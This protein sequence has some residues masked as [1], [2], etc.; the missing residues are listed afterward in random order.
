MPTMS[1]R[2]DRWAHRIE[3]LSPMALLA[4]PQNA[5]THSRAQRRK[6]ERSIRRFGFI[7]P[8]IIDESRN[9]IAGHGRVQAALE[10]GLDRVPV[11][12]IEG[13]SEAEK[14]AYALADNKIA[15]EAGWDR[16]LLASELGEL[17]ALLPAID[18]DLDDTGFNPG[19]I[20][21][22]LSDHAACGREPAD[23]PP[24]RQEVA[25]TRRGDQWRLGA[26]IIRCGDAQSPSD[27]ELLMKGERAR[28]AFIDSP[29]N[30]PVKGHVSGR[31]RAQHKEFAFAS[32]KMSPAEFIAFLK[33]CLSQAALVSDS[34]A[35]H[36]V[37]ID[38]RHVA[39]LIAAGRE[40]YDSMLNLCVWVKTNGGQGSFYRSGHELIG[41]FRAA[42]GAH[43]NNVE[44]GRYGRNRTNVWTYPGVNSFG[45]GRDAALAMHPTP[46]PIALVAD[47]MRDCTSKGDI[48]LDP[49]LGSGTT[50]MAA[51][52]IGRRARGLEYEP[53]YVDVAIRRWQAYT[54]GDATLEDDGRTFNEVE[55]ERRSEASDGAEP[56]GKQSLAQELRDDR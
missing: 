20:D 1:T 23:V 37:C 39:E 22:I 12:K 9:I 49:F 52:K 16:A 21:A 41:I 24:P 33:T 30:V 17:A 56:N 11:I 40:A 53:T 35:V 18:M 15:E 44:L 43:Q 36:Y 2:Q 19:E 54:R 4:N 8:P 25:V 46:K 32:G 26:H 47:A 13:M 31:G 38:W 55:D 27:F 51:E 14:R 5:R 50:L 42:G 48:V 29:Y 3:Y 10:L 28:M 7:N 34:G 45:A 6:I